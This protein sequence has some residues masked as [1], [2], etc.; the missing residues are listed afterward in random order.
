MTH[1]CFSAWE[2]QITLEIVVRFVFCVK[3]GCGD[4]WNISSCI[5]LARNKDFEFLDAEN[6]FKVLEKFDEVLGDFLLRRGS[7]LS[8]R[9]PC[10]NRLFNPK[11][12]GQIGPGVRIYHRLMLSLLGARQKD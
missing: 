1:S 5:A 3:H 8:D 7:D 11:H 10:P 9:K 12:V 2:G 6:R 4:I